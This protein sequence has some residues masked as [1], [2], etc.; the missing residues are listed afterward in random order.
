M[1]ILTEKS[2]H[3]VGC[4]DLVLFGYLRTFEAPVCLESYEINIL[5]ALTSIEPQLIATGAEPKMA[6]DI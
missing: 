3:I 5:D 4:L 6:Q 2:T 1:H